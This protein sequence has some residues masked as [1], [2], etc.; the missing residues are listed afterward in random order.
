MNI[1][2]NR[3]RFRA[4]VINSLLFFIFV[5]GCS[6]KNAGLT[7]SEWEALFSQADL[8]IDTVGVRNVASFDSSSSHQ[9]LVIIDRQYTFPNM[10][11]GGEVFAWEFYAESIDP[12]KLIM[13][14][15]DDSGDLFEMIGESATIVPSTI[16]VNRHILREPIP[17]SKGCMM[18]L[19]QP[20][21]GTIP[22]SKIRGYRTFIAARE[23][24]RP[25]MKRD[26]FAMY[27]WR[28]A[29]RVFWRSTEL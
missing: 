19:L 3:F 9:G 16:G 2:I 6:E 29:M 7:N 26:L 15:F 8:S 28:Y 17:I 22:F 1:V 18:G 20:K 13:V 24:E 23:L 25:F 11:A 14:K 5:T 27:G 4:I 12:I 10:A 21:G